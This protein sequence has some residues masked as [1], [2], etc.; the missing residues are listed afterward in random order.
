MRKHEQELVLH[1][2]VRV[3]PGDL[4]QHICLTVKKAILVYNIS[5]S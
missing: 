3:L 2:R 5:S 1:N 4:D